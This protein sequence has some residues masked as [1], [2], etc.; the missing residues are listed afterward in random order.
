MLLNN[1]RMESPMAPKRIPKPLVYNASIIERV[2]LTDLLAIFKVAPDPIEGQKVE[3]PKFVAGQYAVLGANNERMP[4]LGPVKRAYSIASPPDQREHMEFYVRLVQKPTSTNPLTP[5]LWEMREGSRLWLGPKVTGFFT[6]T[7]TI[8]ED[9][10]RVKL[11]VA[12]GTG[13]APFVS[14]L[15]EFVLK[16]RSEQAGRC[17]ILHGASYEH[18]LAYKQ[19]LE[20]VLND[21]RQRYF[22]TIS[23]PHEEP[24]WN[25]DTGRVETFF[26][27]EKLESIEQRAGFE[28]GFFTPENCVVYVCGL[29]GTIAET[30]IRLIGRGFVPNER[31]IRR[32]L[33][34]PDELPPSLFFEQYD[35]EPIIDLKNEEFVEKLRAAFP[36]GV[37]MG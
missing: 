5:L 6:M 18:D 24:D 34:I 4:E 31:M 28:K 26:D 12:A 29:Q 3:V 27:Q 25:G 35:T 11:F 15:R 7:D 16:R 32:A 36:R 23:R 8:G 21:V 1:N 20:T 10:P 2:D 14:I 30:L 33:Q 22:P 17:I 19:D 9:D 37:E 13:L